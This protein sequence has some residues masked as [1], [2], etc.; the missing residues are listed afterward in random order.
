MRILLYACVYVE[1]ICI[2][3]VCKI[4]VCGQFFAYSYYIFLIL[5]GGVKNTPTQAKYENSLQGWVT[6]SY[7]KIGK[8]SK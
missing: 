1:W 4:N 3:R 8:I 5:L 2:M 7:P 6:K